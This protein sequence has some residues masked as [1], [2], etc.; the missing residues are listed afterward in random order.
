M[1]KQFKPYQPSPTLAQ[2]SQ[3]IGIPVPKIIKLDAG[4]NPYVRKLLSKIKLNPFQVTRYPDPYCLEL[5]KALSVYTGYPPEWIMCGNGS[6]ELIDLVIRLILV[7]G[8]QLIINPPT[9]PMYEFYGNLNY[10]KVI[11]ITRQSDLNVNLRKI[12][13]TISPKVKLIFVDSP[14]NPAGVVCPRETII[15]LLE[16]T[17]LTVV[18]DEAYFEYCGKTAIDLVNK[19]PNLIILRTFS[20]WAGLAGARIGYLVAQPE[21]I[22]KLNAI[23]SPYNVN[24]FAQI[25]AIQVL[26]NKQK[27]LNLIKTITKD[28]RKMIQKL[29]ALNKA[30]VYPTESAYVVV[31]I[32]KAKNLKQFLYQ[33]G[34]LVKYLELPTLGKCLRISICPAPQTNQLVSTI[35]RFYEV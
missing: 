2:I 20:K 9:F 21:I 19:Y 4:E 30:T 32:P 7:P 3:E 5:K 34:I 26:N 1:I 13:K 22:S 28:R 23:K 29:T 31:K 17:K 10:A 12:T 6:D 8:D 15:T 24:V 25:L 33:N 11:K 14:G 35:R 16:E 27:Y 18:V